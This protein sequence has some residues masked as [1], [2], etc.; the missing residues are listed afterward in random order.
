MIAGLG[1]QNPK[2]PQIANMLR[3]ERYA[4]LPAQNSMALGFKG[5]AIPALAYSF[6]HLQFRVPFFPESTAMTGSCVVTGN[7]I[8]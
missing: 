1:Q 2:I 7:D 8:G 3:R 6:L 5:L 4:R